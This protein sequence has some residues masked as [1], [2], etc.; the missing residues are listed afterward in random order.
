MPMTSKILLDG[1]EIRIASRELIVRGELRRLP[2]RAFDVLLALAEHPGK[3]VAKEDLLRSVWGG[4][5]V[6]GSNLT[7]AVA[8]IRKAMGEVSPGRSYVETVPRMG[9][10]IA[11]QAFPLGLATEHPDPTTTQPVTPRL[12][13]AAPETNRWRTQVAL[14]CTVILLAVAAVLAV[15]RRNG[16]PGGEVAELP[17]TALEGDELSGSFSPDGREVVFTWAKKNE[18]ADIYLKAID[19]EAVRPFVTSDAQEVGPVFSPDGRSIAFLRLGPEASSVIV[20]PRDG[21]T[22]RSITTTSNPYFAF[23]GSPGPYLA[24]TKD[25]RALIYV[26]KKALELFRLDTSTAVQLTHP[27]A[28]AA[29]GDADPALSAD[30]KTLVFSRVRGYGSADLYRLRLNEKFEPVENPELLFGNGSWNRS[31]AWHPDGRHV[32]FTSG[33]WGRQRLWYLDVHRLDS[34]KPISD[35]GADAQQPAV[36]SSGDILYTRWFFREQI[37]N[38]SLLGPGEASGGTLKPLFTSTRGDSLPRLSRD[39]SQIAFQSD[40]SGSA[41]LW[42][43]ASDGTDLRKITS[44]GGPPSGSPD[45][46]PDGTRVAF[47]RVVDRQRDIFICDLYGGNLRRLTD[48]PAEDVVPR[49]SS[50]GRSVYFASHREGTPQVWKTDVDSGHSV[51]MTHDGGYAC[52]ESPDGKTLYFTQRD[53]SSTP[54]LAM[55]TSG[56]PARKILDD[57][58]QRAMA[59][60]N[61]GI[62]FVPARA[63]HELHYLDFASGAQRTVLSVADTILRFV[64]VDK[65]HHTAAVQVP[66]PP[67]GD[68]I[69]IRRARLD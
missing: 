63:P 14:I 38:V 36:S 64:T 48:D 62:Y 34:A 57:V 45:L 55:P 44:F 47:D 11:V 9:Y 29:L 20:K 68:L 54:V 26:H 33:Q 50:D 32:V 8:Q 56:G 69:L 15:V 12:E 7:Q 1:A 60:T 22:E 43:A 65:K 23:L 21:G 42:T 16:Q 30:G 10:R 24:W 4:D 40:R 19:S 6:D 17:F 13:S 3:V 37:W 31:P 51:R 41:E 27:P 35:M 67:P 59:V 52:D 28:S 39:G 66:G 25:G 2:W 46:S 53:D 58:L 18:N 5:A 61:E 49:W